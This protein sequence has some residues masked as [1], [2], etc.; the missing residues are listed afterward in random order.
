MCGA[1]EC[2]TWNIPPPHTPLD[3]TAAAA[4]PS[5]HVMPPTAPRPA[6]AA[7][8]APGAPPAAPA[9]RVL[10]VV[11]QKGGVGKTTTAVNLAACMALAGRRTLLV[12]CDPQGNA[13]SAFGL[14][15]EGFPGTYDVLTGGKSLEMVKR[16]TPVDRLDVVGANAEL[17]GAE[18]ELLDAEGRERLLA[19][20]LADPTL[21]DYDFI[22]LDAP[23]SLGLLTLNVLT[24]ADALVVPVQCEYYA[25]EGLGNLVRTVERVK[26]SFNP[27][28]EILGV[29]LT[30][31]DGRLNIA[32]QV[33]EEVRAHFPGKVFRT[34]IA[35][36]VRLAE[37]PS[38]GMPVILYDFR[39]PAS[40]AYIA[41]TEEVLNAA[42]PQP[43]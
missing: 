14:P 7:A 17:Y 18:A 6:R 32:N 28:L 37:A 36:S 12:D 31:H 13:T 40:R 29:A 20:A 24:A 27:G 35:R 43:R 26:G 4:V 2:S 25:L 15:K 1:G 16:P 30:M 3:P 42:A 19:A 41:L 34:V 11:N 5:T 9:R 39:S 38:H 23:P 21:A 8:T 33:A 10:G 22:V